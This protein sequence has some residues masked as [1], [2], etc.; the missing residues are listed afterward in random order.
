MRKKRSQPSSSGAVAL[1]DPY[2]GRLMESVSREI[3][4][5]TNRQAERIKKLIQVGL[6]LSSE[7]DNKSLLEMIV[8]EARAL[9]LADAD[10]LYIVS[11]DGARLDFVILQNDTM[12][13]RLGGRSGGTITLPPVQL[14]AGASENHANVSSHVALSGNVVNI[15]DVYEAE[16]FD[17]TGPRKYDAATGYRSRSMLV[18][19][20]RNHLNVIIG[21]LQLL[22]AKN[23]LTGEVQ[24]FP[25][26]TVDLAASLASQA[27]V[28][29]TNAQLIRDLRNLFDSF[30]KSI[31][32]AIDEK[33]P[34]TGG[35]VTRVV[36][37]TMMIADAVNRACD[38]PFAAVGM[39]EDGLEELKLAAWL[40]DV[41]KITLPEHIIDKRTKLETVFDRQ[42]LVKARFE[43]AEKCVEADM[44]RRQLELVLA[45]AA[46][47]AL[48]EAS[49]AAIRAMDALKDDLNFVLSCNC[50]GEFMDDAKIARLREIAGKSFAYDGEQRPFL[51]EN[52]LMNLCVRKGSLNDGERRIVE[53]H[54]RMT[55]R[56]LSELPFPK[57]I[58]Q[59]PAIAGAHHEKLDGTGYPDRLTADGISLQARIMAVADVFEAL[60]AKDRPYKEPMKLSQAIKIMGFMKKDK[61]IDPDILDL[62]L[63]S[64]LHLEYARQYL[65]PEQ[66]D[67]S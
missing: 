22:N 37:L 57:R 50:P 29:L 44:A 18:I 60:T 32:T 54:T 6:A 19:P 33:S 25:D 13:V 47:E 52:E 64:G 7:K 21:V 40:H 12:G 55:M 28:A 67:M 26:E 31:A 36:A 30:I 35:H 1:N 9:T 58:A 66:I 39:D 56:I 20:L 63:G 14:Y 2:F 24:A 41:G 38:G 53:N 11:E 27:A 3:G 65:A 4:L 17:F 45:G 48:A 15:P 5:Y 49:H 34:Y 62:F 61:H 23:E 46:P 51:T 42:E 59:V 43:L 16:G 10:T 8:T